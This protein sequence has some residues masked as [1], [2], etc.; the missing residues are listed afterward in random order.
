MHTTVRSSKILPAL[1]AILL[2][3]LFSASAQRT[4][5]GA[6]PVPAA[7]SEP[8]AVVVNGQNIP[9]SRYQAL[10]NDQ[11]S[12][13]KK[14]GQAPVID[15]ATEDALLMQLVDAELFR[16]EAARRKVLVTREEAIR[17]ILKNPPDFVRPAFTDQHGVFL[18]DIFQ[19]VVLN[20]DMITSVIT[21]TQN[22][23]T[24]R[25]R[26][27]QD[28]EQV[29]SFVQT[30]ETK[31]KLSDA[32]MAEKPLTAKMI[33]DHYF[34]ERTRFNGS[35]I[36]IL[37]NTIPDS[38]VPVTDDELRAWYD[39]HIE[40]Y[41][42][43][44][45][46]Y[47]SGLILPI[48]PVGADSARHK[49]Q[50]NEGRS[51]I[52]SAAPGAR[53]GIVSTLLQSLPPNR[54]PIDRAVNLMQ[55]PDVVRERV[56]AAKAGDLIGPIPGENGEEVFFFID[57]TEEM[58]DTI[59]H[60]RHILVKTDAESGV[61]DSVARNFLTLLRDSIRTEDQFKKA[62]EEYDQDG[63][64]ARS[65]DLGFIGRGRMVREFDSAVFA[66]PVGQVVGPV[67]T[68]FGYHLIW[69][70]D[71]FTTGY[72]IRELRFPLTPSEGARQNV[73]RDAEAYASALRAN[74]AHAIDSIFHYLKM[75][76]PHSLADTTLLK[77]LDLYGDA[78]TATSFAF[79][80]KA[81]DVGV[82]PVPY[83]RVIIEKV[84][85]VW[86]TGV[87]PYEKIRENYVIPHVRRSKQLEML[88][89]RIQKLRDTMTADMTLGVIRLTAPWAEA[90]M[91][92]N[93]ALAPPIDEDSTLLDSLVAI[94]PNHGISG[95]VRGKHAYYFLRIVDRTVTPTESEFQQDKALYTADYTERYRQRLLN[96]VITR[97]RQYAE[98]DDRRPGVQ[99][100]I[101]P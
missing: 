8:A 29:I 41:R 30:T 85:Q 86:P 45:S 2:L 89:P 42:F 31:R 92:Q 75:R 98:V 79:N 57:G 52:T 3:P 24:V 56:R 37:H 93:G 16:Q 38:L 54:F 64:A 33:R 78:L 95:P 50:M 83:D 67:K 34:A 66:A 101:R 69:V 65:G 18:K 61:P 39:S 91:I 97:A 62:A 90:F 1:A 96:D 55:I 5:S 73:M 7:K 70:T 36:R 59:A 23:D 87:A 51:M 4:R 72:R 49:T 48:Y 6:K 13:M 47:V 71:R 68:R 63:A 32:L 15:Q 46:R 11:I 88:K 26:W 58:S 43:P 77:R 99:G 82:I 9:Y 81:G 20:P 27:K 21:T 25:A 14:L 10:Y 80:A 76:Y 19:K 28:L 12:Y 22:L 17:S 60:A 53:S 84:L 35:F 74:N 40:D 94:T 100:A 44:S